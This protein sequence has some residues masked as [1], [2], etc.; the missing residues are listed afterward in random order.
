MSNAPRKSISRP[1][2]SRLILI[3]SL[4]LGLWL[5]VGLAD[6]GDG[7]LSSVAYWSVIRSY[8]THLEVKYD[9]RGCESVIV[10]V[11]A[12]Q[13]SKNEKLFS[14]SCRC[15]ECIRLTHMEPI[16]SRGLVNS[17]LLKRLLS[18]RSGVRSD[19][20]KEELFSVCKTVKLGDFIV[21]FFNFVWGGGD[22]AL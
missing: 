21:V 14:A 15:L 22:L 16:K 8:L 10:S 12:K 18:R 13:N 19:R 2:V 4:V 7:V 11:Q 1:H 9:T 20:E 3:L 17:T 5:V 6:G